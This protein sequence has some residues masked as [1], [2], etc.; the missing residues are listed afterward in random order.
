MALPT[1]SPYRMPEFSDLP[2]N[3][4]LWTPDPKRAVLLIHDMQK[5]FLAPFTPGVSP[6]AEL[7][8]NIQSLKRQCDAYGIPVIYSAQ[9][10]GQ[11]P[12][13]RGLLGDF[14]GP[15][16]ADDPDQQEIVD[17]LAPGDSDIVLTKWRYSAFQRTDLLDI[18]RRLR[19]DQLVVCGVY[20]HIGCLLTAC[21]AFMHD[22][23]PFFVADAVADFS[24]EHHRMALTYAAERCGMTTTTH[25]LLEDLKKTRRTAGES[26]SRSLTLED[27][28][29][30]VARVLILDPTELNDDED[31]IN[32]GLDSIRIMK[33]VEQFRR[34]GAEVTFVELAERP[35]IADWWRLLASRSPRQASATLPDDIP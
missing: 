30:Q 32:R 31:L 27:V 12:E 15:G 28:R 33:L 13:Q 7:I 23:Q 14:W 22:V 35:T 1:I 5:Y 8:Q 4:V 25:R 18:L 26:G 2:K 9:P 6:V 10:G 20:A 21:E 17:E 19:R 11:S 29:E 16:M 34:A 3:R 24:W